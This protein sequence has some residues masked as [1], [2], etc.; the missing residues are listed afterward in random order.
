MSSVG[1]PSHGRAHHSRHPF[2]LPVHPFPL[3]VHPLPL[4]RLRG[5]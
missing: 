2:P 1:K 4:Q 5:R 3:P